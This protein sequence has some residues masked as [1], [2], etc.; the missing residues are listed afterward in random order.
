MPVELTE[1]QIDNL[2]DFIECEFIDSVR[3]DADMDNID[4]IVDMMNALQ[5]LRRANGRT[6]SGT[7]IN[8]PYK[9]CCV[10]VRTAE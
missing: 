3:K 9:D 1:S 5:I 8:S 7:E 2:I 6:N 4:Y 10:S